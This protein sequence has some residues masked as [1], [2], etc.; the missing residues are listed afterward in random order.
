ML[1]DWTS[2]RAWQSQD[3]MS[4]TQ[5]PIAECTVRGKYTQEFFLK[6]CEQKFEYLLWKTWS[7][8]WFFFIVHTFVNK[9]LNISSQKHDRE[10]LQREHLEEK[11]FIN[12]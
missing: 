9:N 6:V 1:K 2:K 11:E 10:H 8:L 12:L 5:H 7:D 3:K 4:K